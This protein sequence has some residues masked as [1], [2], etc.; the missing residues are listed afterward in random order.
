MNDENPEVE[1]AEGIQFADSGG[2]NVITATEEPFVEDGGVWRRDSGEHFH[3]LHLLM[4]PLY[5]LLNCSF[6]LVP[7]V[8]A[9]NCPI[10]LLRSEASTRRLLMALWFTLVDGRL[11]AWVRLGNGEVQEVE[12]NSPCLRGYSVYS[13]MVLTAA[14]DQFHCLDACIFTYIIKSKYC[15]YVWFI[16]LA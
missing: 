8:W 6:Q 12:Y 2:I 13:V 1:S 9:F 15:T 5:A 14:F 16:C 7:S 3:P 4:V 11:T 10:P